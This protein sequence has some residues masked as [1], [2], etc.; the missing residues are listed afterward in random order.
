MFAS[1]RESSPSLLA[2]LR[3]ATQAQHAAL[4][5]LVAPAGGTLTRERY[6]ALLLGSLSAL[7]V[8]EPRLA[9]WFEDF[10]VPSRVSALQADLADLSAQREP[11]EVRAP[12]LPHIAD[13][14]GCAYVIEGSALGGIVMARSLRQSSDLHLPLRYL[15][16]RGDGT[17]RHFRAFCERLEAWGSST[18]DRERALACACASAT[19]AAYAQGIERALRELVA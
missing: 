18:S 8:L 4:D 11:P 16:L 15:A 14:Y 1:K 5:A 3:A 19:F 12:E 9:A 7:R 2:E 6:L 10:A 13:A 17:G